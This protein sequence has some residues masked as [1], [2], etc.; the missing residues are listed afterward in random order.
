MTLF[1]N[2]PPGI[3]KKTKDSVPTN[4]SPTT[5]SKLVLSPLQLAP[6]ET[7]H[8]TLT[9]R[10]YLGASLPLPTDVAV[11]VTP[12]DR[13][14]VTLVG[15]KLVML[16]GSTAGDVTITV[17][18]PSAKQTSNKLVVTITNDPPIRVLT[19]VRVTSSSYAPQPS[20]PVTIT[21]QAL[22]Q[23]GLPL[24]QPGIV[25]TWTKT[26]SGGSFASSTSMTDAT[27][28][29]TVAF[30]PSATGGTSHVVT[31][32]DGEITADSDPIVVQAAVARVLT[33]IGVSAAT[34][35]PTTGA[36]DTIT[37]Q[38]FDQ[39]G[40]PLK[41]AGLT[42]TWTKTGT[43]GSF[44][45]GTSVTDANGRATVD[46]TVSSTGGTSHVVTA[47]SGSVS[48]ASAPIVA[49][50][51]APP[52]PVFTSLGISSSSYSPTV[53]SVVTITAQAFDQN[54]APL[55]KSG[56]TVT[57][58]KSGT[59]GTLGA[60]SSVTDAT[61]KA[62]VLFTVSGVAGTVHTATGTA[63][64]PS[65]PI[66]GVSSA[67]TTQ[68]AV[69]QTTAQK[70]MSLF[71]PAFPT[72][73]DYTSRGYQWYVDRFV[74]N[75]DALW[76]ACGA[77][78]DGCNNIAQYDRP[79]FYYY[80]WII[81]GDSKWL[82]RANATLLNWRNAV[83]AAGWAVAPHQTMAI[84]LYAHWLVTGDALS[85][86]AILEIASRSGLAFY[87]STY[88]KLEQGENRI[89]ARIIE[90]LWMA[91]TVQP[92]NPT[93]GTALEKAVANTLATQN[94]AG[95]FP[96]Q[97]TCGG[98]LNYMGALLMD[99]L[100]RLH[101]KRPKAVYNTAI[102]TCVRKFANWLWSTEWDA[103]AQAFP[104]M[105]ILCE[106]TGGPG[107]AIDLNAIFTP[108][109]GWLGRLDNDASWFTKGD[110]IFAGIQVAF[111]EGNRQ[112]SENYYSSE[113]YLGYKY[114]Q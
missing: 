113:R 29:A 91:E 108:M 79:L 16:A 24:S 68:A 57:W 41:Q 7:G 98:Q 36:V 23:D 112:F 105:S 97:G 14:T 72:V 21:A 43:G 3:G 42:F 51:V 17:T 71:G 104:Y 89:Q 59:G 55:A 8:A 69:T 20:T 53:A 31:A 107:P 33:T 10:N 83:Q 12:S 45:S 22:D 54:G 6:G 63:T 58:S 19:G 77:Q 47:T 49:T 62:T 65:G 80:W 66:V 81:T 73:A 52:P 4:Q 61:G 64:G 44:A 103:G 85:K 93:W 30:T 78:W 95:F 86:Q 101:D 11:V 67:I 9:A 74:I 111:V 25:F 39:D 26:G 87:D 106:G 114:N 96:F 35:T 27:G 70:I 1:E 5:V 56:I 99:T 2:V 84:S 92:D 48:G 32:T 37:A 50:V 90:L 18:S 13:M 40:L 76:T 38:A 28:K 100:T 88:M 34:Y 15:S 110:Q 102:E 46:F 60:T 94:S 75:A 82:D 109:F